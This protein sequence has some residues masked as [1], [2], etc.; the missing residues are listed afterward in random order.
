[1]VRGCNTH[2][3]QRYP[4]VNLFGVYTQP[5]NKR[6][7]SD[8]RMKQ[9]RP[10]LFHNE[11]RTV[12]FAAQTAW[13][14]NPQSTFYVTASP[15]KELGSRIQDPNSPNLSPPTLNKSHPTHPSKGVACTAHYKL[16]QTIAT[17]DPSRSKWKATRSSQ[18]FS[19]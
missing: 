19:T 1:M 9:E 8:Q 15:W 16:G 11:H 14:M 17:I 6:H 12:A 10:M 2:I 7:C 4:K 5:F 13:K 3:L 18:S